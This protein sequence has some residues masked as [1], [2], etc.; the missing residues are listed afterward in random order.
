MREISW[1]SFSR[2]QTCSPWIASAWSTR[3]SPGPGL[4]PAKN[5]LQRRGQVA[6]L[7]HYAGC[8][9]AS[10]ANAQQNGVIAQRSRLQVIPAR[11]IKRKRPGMRGLM[12]GDA[13]K[14]L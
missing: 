12:Y 11:A 5:R 6:F 8:G 13:N 4:V 2:E 1:G 10:D 9:V 7:K 3:G 14:L